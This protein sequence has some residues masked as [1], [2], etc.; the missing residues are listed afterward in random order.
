M[1]E[2]SRFP[3]WLV[4]AGSIAALMV[5]VEIG[6]WLARVSS[7]A[8]EPGYQTPLGSLVAAL[9]GLLAFILAFTFGMT[10]N[11]FEQRRQ[12]LL[13]EANAIRT[14]Y[15]NAFLVPSRQGQEMQRLLRDYVEVRLNLNKENVGER[16]SRA[17]E[18]H[19]LL[20]GEIKDLMTAKIDSD[21]RSS[22]I[23]SMNQLINLNQSRITVGLQY[24]LPRAI[25]LPLYM[26]SLISMIALGYQMGSTGSKRLVGILLLAA[27]LAMVFTMITDLDRPGEGKFRVSEQPLKD[28]KEM[29][30]E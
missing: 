26:L 10:A 9:L 25:W 3:L 16:L 28:V 27:A 21:F 22:V 8:K 23:A 7:V 24:Q 6:L 18:I 15:L 11:R 14:V 4:F 19:R 2:F 29:M 12:L 5:A 1:L 17:G 30:A 13:E 20:W